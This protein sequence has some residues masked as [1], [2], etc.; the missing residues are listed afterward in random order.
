MLVQGL[1]GYHGI[2]SRAEEAR[3][4]EELLQLLQHPKAA[5]VAEETRYCVNLY[6]TGELG[7]PGKDTLAF[8]LS[9]APTLQAV[10]YRFFVLGL[11][12]SPPNVC[13]INEMIGN[14]SGYPVHRKPASVGAYFGL[15]NLVST[16]VVHLQHRDCPWYPR[17]H[18]SPRSLFVVSEP[19]L[20]EYGMGY[21]RTA[22][23]FHSFEYATRVSKDYRIEVL[24]A[25]VESARH[26]LL[27]DAVGLT[28]AAQKSSTAAAAASPGEAE[29]PRDAPNPP[30][31]SVI[32]PWLRQIRRQLHE[33]EGAAGGPPGPSMDPGSGLSPADVAPGPD[34]SLK[35]VVVDGHA[36]R[37]EMEAQL[38]LGKTPRTFSI[39]SDA[40]PAADAAFPAA[41]GRAKAASPARRRLEAL[42]TRY[43]FAKHLQSHTAVSRSNDGPTLIRG[44][45]PGDGKKF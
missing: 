15:L 30:P 37:R 36:L 23:P 20:S 39:N 38:L 28:A 21:K 18:V 29:G 41:E 25:T 11:I 44:H 34:G 16:T 12:P 42:R 27:R 26:R 43:E 33:T 14:F 13:Q 10:L 8:A 32:D 7:L 5:Y 19:C 35:T 2:I 31:P 45:A 9:R 22:Q 6:E 24:F 40:P 1:V 4:C 17:L 3:L